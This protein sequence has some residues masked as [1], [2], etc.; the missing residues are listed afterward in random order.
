MLNYSFDIKKT[1]EKCIDDGI[2]AA[3]ALGINNLEISAVIDGRPLW[4]LDG[5]QLEALRDKIIDA[6][7]IIALISLD[8]R[9]GREETKRFFRAAHLLGALYIKVDGELPADELDSLAHTA[10][11]FD[12]KALIENN[13]D[14]SIKTDDDL[15][16][17]SDGTQRSNLGI[18][19]NPAEFVR[20][21]HHPFFHMFYRS[22][23][24]NDIVFLRVADSLYSGGF[25]DL[26]HGNCEIKELISILCARSFDRYGFFSISDYAG[27]GSAARALHDIKQLYKLM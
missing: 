15:A 11:S 27:E 13:A 3:S 23:L 17:V 8:D 6:G 20:L 26:G 9:L 7:K 1:S 18:I 19:Y 25:T 24:K 14:T 2:S 21:S 16:R 4:T 10:E 5:R 22:H 12:M